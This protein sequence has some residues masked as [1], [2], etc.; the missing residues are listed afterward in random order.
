ML[1]LEIM[2]FLALYLV[3]LS[4]IICDVTPSI[5]S[6]SRSIIG[7]NTILSNDVKPVLL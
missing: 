1:Y 5:R 2:F 4:V 6:S 7:V 3:L